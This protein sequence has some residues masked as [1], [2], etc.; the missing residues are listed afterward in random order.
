MCSIIYFWKSLPGC[1]SIFFI[2]KKVCQVGVGQE[3]Y[4]NA[5]NSWSW[6]HFF[7]CLYTNVNEVSSLFPFLVS[8]VCKLFTCP[9]SLSDQYTKTRYHT[10]DTIRFDSI[11]VHCGTSLKSRSIRVAKRKENAEPSCSTYYFWFAGGYG[12]MLDEWVQVALQSSPNSI[13]IWRVMIE[14]GGKFS[15]Q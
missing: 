13:W 11:Q 3:E 6:L 14:E 9:I 2:W 4:Q 1:H 15:G 5:V 12:W 8:V 10:D 7:Q